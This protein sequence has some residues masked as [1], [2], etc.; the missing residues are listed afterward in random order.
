MAWLA[1]SLSA[2]VTGQIIEASGF[3]LALVQGWTRGPKAS[4][5]PSRPEEVDAAVR[6]QGSA[7]TVNCSERARHSIV[8]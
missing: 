6:H 4:N 2:G 3:G 7:L 8:E 1:S 5:L